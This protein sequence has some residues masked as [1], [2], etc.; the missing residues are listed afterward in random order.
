MKTTADSPAE[1][2]PISKKCLN[3]MIFLQMQQALTENPIITTPPYVWNP[4]PYE[5]IG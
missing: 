1:H 4:A 2:P 5:R 3:P